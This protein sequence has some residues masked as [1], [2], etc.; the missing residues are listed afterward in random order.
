MAYFDENRRAVVT[1]VGMLNPMPEKKNEFTHRKGET[2]LTPVT[3]ACPEDQTEG[4]N[5]LQCG[6]NPVR[7]AV[8]FWGQISQIPSSLSPKRDCSS[9]RVK[10][11][12]K[13]EIKMR[14]PPP[15]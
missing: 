10:K 14:C 12:G 15:D 7:S 9:E 2:G 8:P 6:F 5:L 3:T 13:S 1:I 4:K 11:G